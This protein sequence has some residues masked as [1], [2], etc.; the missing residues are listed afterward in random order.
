MSNQPSA[1]A[2]T[3]LPTLSGGRLQ[4]VE[5]VQSIELPE[6]RTAVTVRIDGA[7]LLGITR[8]FVDELV[9]ALLV[10]RPG[11]TLVVTRVN[12][13]TSRIFNER[14]RAREVADRLLID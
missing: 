7:A 11:V 8:S 14:A 6:P 2:T 10:A 4:A 5:L 3:S 13:N 12:D 9:L 1:P